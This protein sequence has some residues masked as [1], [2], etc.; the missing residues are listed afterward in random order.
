[1]PGHQ[2]ILSGKT[3]PPRTFAAVQYDDS[4]YWISGQDLPSK[5]GFTFLMMFLSMVETGTTPQGPVVTLPD[6]LIHNTNTTS[7]RPPR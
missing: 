7:P 6:E 2:S 1:M 4:W 5:R 3:L